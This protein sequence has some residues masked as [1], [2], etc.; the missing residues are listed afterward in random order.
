MIVHDKQ[1]FNVFHG[2]GILMTINVINWWEMALATG[3]QPRKQQ[4]L[5]IAIRFT[6]HI[7]FVF[8]EQVLSYMMDYIPI[9]T[10]RAMRLMHDWAPT[11][12]SAPVQQFLHTVYQRP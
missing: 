4:T 12:F 10:L 2:N 9:A 11:H 5:P 1:L 6:G 7:Y 3:G 8:L